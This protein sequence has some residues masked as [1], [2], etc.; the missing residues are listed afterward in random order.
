MIAN[1][2]ELSLVCKIA[3][4]VLTFPFLQAWWHLIIVYGS[5]SYLVCR[6]FTESKDKYPSWTELL[7]LEMFLSRSTGNVTFWMAMHLSLIR[8]VW[9]LTHLL[10]FL[11][12][13]ND[14]QL[15]NCMRN[16]DVLSL[17]FLETPCCPVP[18]NLASLL[19]A[20][21]QIIPSLMLCCHCF[22]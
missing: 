9:K 10:S 15:L 1:Y 3:S 18:H 6:L 11:S 12:L 17:Q 7:S 2:S 16:N 13:H 5:V 21:S 22:F 20:N 8:Y 19:M 14:F 4:V